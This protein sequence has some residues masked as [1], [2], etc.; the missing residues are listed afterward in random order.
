MARMWQKHLGKALMKWA[1]VRGGLSD[2]DMA[3]ALAADDNDEDE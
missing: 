1:H 2:A 3:A